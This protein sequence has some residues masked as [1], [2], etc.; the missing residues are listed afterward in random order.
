MQAGDKVKTKL[1]SS[2][3][4]NRTGVVKFVSPQKWYHV[5]LDFDGKIRTY[6]LHELESVEG[7]RR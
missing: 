5:E 2:R 6:R 1:S 7:P 4:P 3:E